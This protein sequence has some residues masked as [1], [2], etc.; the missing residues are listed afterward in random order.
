MK[1]EVDRLLLLWPLPWWLSCCFAVLS[2]M[3]LTW[4]FSPYD[5][6]IL[7][8][9]SLGIL[10]VL[11]R[12]Q[13]PGRSFW[14][15]WLFGCGW[16]GWGTHWVY[17]STHDYGGVP[18]AVAVALCGL[19]AAGMALYPALLGYVSRRWALPDVW[20]LGVVFPVGW[21][22]V[23]WLRSWLFTGF[24]WFNL[25]YTQL[26]SV[27][28]GWAPVWGV[29]AVSLALALT[30]GW[31]LLLYYQRSWRWIVPIVAVWSGGW[32]LQQAVWVQSDSKPIR[33]SLVQ[34]NIQQD[35]KW[36][37]T[38]YEPTLE[39]YWQLTHQ[40]LDHSDL[41]IWPESSIPGFYHEV[42]AGF[43]H[44]LTAKAQHYG[45]D[46]LLGILVETPTQDYYNAV[47]ALTATAP[48]FYYKQHLVPFSEYLP[49]HGLNFLV[50][51]FNMP[52]SGF[53]AGTAR[54]PLLKVHGWRV[55]ISICYEGAF[56][57]EIMAALPEADI[58]V[59]VSNDGWF[60]DSIALAQNL[61]MARMRALEAG[62]YLLRA[63]NTGLTAVIDPQG[64]IQSQAL[65]HTIA[66]VQ[67]QVYAQHG[68]TP[69]LYWGNA[70][71]VSVSLALILMAYV[72]FFFRER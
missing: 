68:E 2:G 17:I 19:L 63:T 13:T 49:G 1:F 70:A 23:E 43:L 50:E 58:L 25:G 40:A 56:G 67:D 14:L 18:S 53:T 62:R 8:P 59:N 35:Q 6:V 27:L 60:G 5:Q 3:A 12:C 33:V 4:A 52:I 20:Q 39:L 72:S 65:P 46:L 42:K 48:Q 30:V 10:F 36:Q 69:Y 31:S 24:P 16:F 54:Q 22:L 55:G 47:V 21:V 71:V 32:G 51:Q 11:W 38:N 37:T 57:P 66:L 64:R 26:D 34:A 45:V 28:A 9:M 15:G 44:H 29:H 41:I 7:A 61:Q